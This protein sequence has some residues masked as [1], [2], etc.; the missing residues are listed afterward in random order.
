LIVSPFA[1]LARAV[2]SVPVPLLAVLVTVM[3]AACRLA[4][5]VASKARDTAR[6]RGSDV[7]DVS[8]V[9]MGPFFL[10]CYGPY[11]Q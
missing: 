10:L 9:F 8:L 11:I 5:A 2:R 4:G 7:S 3:V 1:A 6:A